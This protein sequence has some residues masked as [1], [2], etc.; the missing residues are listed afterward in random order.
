MLRFS[1]SSHI[2]SLPELS[3]FR[4]ATD[5]KRGL[6]TFLCQSRATSSQSSAR[7][8]THFPYWDIAVFH[9]GWLPRNTG[10]RPRTLPLPRALTQRLI[11][12]TVRPSGNESH[13]LPHFYSYQ[14]GPAAAPYPSS[15]SGA[16]S[17]PLSPQEGTTQLTHTSV[18][19]MEQRA[20]ERPRCHRQ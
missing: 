2:Y 13:L 19:P 11:A 17:R 16:S 1:H 18:P 8:R 7:D 3:P 6:Q 14:W 4:K 15:P 12:N 10:S 20:R 9:K 5:I